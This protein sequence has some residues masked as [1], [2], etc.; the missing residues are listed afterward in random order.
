[1]DEEKIATF[2]KITFLV[3]R[4][5]GERRGREKRK[6]R[7]QEEGIKRVGGR[8]RERERERR[9]P[10]TLLFFNLNFFENM[11]KTVF[12]YNFFAFF[13]CFTCQ[14]FSPFI[15]RR[16]FFTKILMRGA[17]SLKIGCHF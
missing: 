15:I 11:S 2:F 13:N 1:M 5:G 14:D 10:S 7:G 12:N 16:I 8:V 3:R 4:E 17:G 6:R 9:A